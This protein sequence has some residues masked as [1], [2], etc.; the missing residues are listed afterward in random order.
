MTGRRAA[1]VYAALYAPSAE[2]LRHS[3]PEIGDGLQAQLVALYADPSARVAETVA[4]NLAGAQRAI[5]RYREALLR[6]EAGG[7]R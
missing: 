6:E 3:L 5:L 2:S 1:T 4:S 7:G